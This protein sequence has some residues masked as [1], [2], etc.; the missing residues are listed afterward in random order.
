MY[1]SADKMLAYCQSIAEEFH[2][3][4]NRIRSFVKHNLSS[5]T[6]NESILREF[7]SS[8]VPTNYAVGQGFICN[9]FEENA[10]SKQ[11]DILVYDQAHSPLVYADGPVKIVFPDAARLVIEVKTSLGKK[12]TEQ[13]LWNIQSAKK[14][15][16]N[17]E[18][19]VFAFKSPS[20]DTVRKHLTS[21]ISLFSEQDLPRAILLFDKNVIIYMPKD[22][23][24]Q[25]PPRYSFT[26]P[27]DRKKGQVI[28]YLLAVLLEKTGHLEVDFAMNMSMDVIQKYTEAS[29]ED[30]PIRRASESEA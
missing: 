23:F 4:R 25:G 9:P 21:F 13:A 30:I 5:G 1:T 10:I 24:Q 2:S 8:H 14:L 12:D 15:N 7:L 6:A 3:R 26:V 19:V 17:I 27:I 18:G 16:R 22:H 11:C 29:G 20:P 28:T